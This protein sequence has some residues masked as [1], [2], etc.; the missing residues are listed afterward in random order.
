MD[1]LKCNKP[2]AF[3]K[4]RQKNPVKN[5]ADENVKGVTISS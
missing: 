2:E 4:L 5:E 3:C 1:F